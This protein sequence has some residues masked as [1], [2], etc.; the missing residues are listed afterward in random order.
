MVF[1]ASGGNPFEGET[2]KQFT[3]R[4]FNAPMLASAWFGAV[5]ASLLATRRRREQ[6]RSHKTHQTGVASSADT[7]LPPEIFTLNPV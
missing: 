2:G 3:P 6:A 4:G 7:E 1:S 5:G